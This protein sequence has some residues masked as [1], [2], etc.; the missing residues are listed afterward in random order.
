MT[1]WNIYL[2]GVG[3]QGIGLL[4]D[5]L[6]RALIAIGRSP[7]TSDTHGLA[8]R[9]GS[10]V[11]HIRIS[12]RPVGPIVPPGQADLVLGLE[13]L[14]ALRATRAMMKHGGQLIYCDVA[15]QP[16]AVRM[17][18]A[19]YPSNDEV[20]AAVRAKQGA[21]LRVPVDD[22]KDA[23]LQNI[24]LLSRLVT[25]GIITGLTPDRVLAAM[26]EVLPQRAFETNRAF[27]TSRLSD[28]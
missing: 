11:S 17:N 16:I 22:L 13:R 27:F 3:G 7:M 6:A 9:G 21:A 20:A 26:G 10:V 23:R 5:V 2:T 1:A 19:G 25:S 28:K 24:A 4:S 15:V 8:Q 12:S 18:T 14:E